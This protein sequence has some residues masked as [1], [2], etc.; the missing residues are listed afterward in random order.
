MK[1]SLSTELSQGA[2]TT[3]V[4]W[5]WCRF[6]PIST[7]RVSLTCSG[8]YINLP[9]GAVT[10]LIITL[11]LKAPAPK[12]SGKT[13]REKINQLDPFG[14]LLFMPGVI[15]LLLALQWGGSTYPWHSA[16]I[17]VL[18]L[19]TGV[20]LFGFIAIQ[21]YTKENATVPPRII[22]QRSIASGFYYAL[23]I[24]STMMI[25]VYFIAI[26]F[27]AIENISAYE[28]GIR[29]L[30]LV[31][32]L[33]VGSALSGALVSAV[34]YYTPFMII[35]TGFMAIGGGLLTTFSV[36]TSRAQ[37]IG[38]QVLFGFGL[39]LALQMPSMAAQTVLKN[40]DV[41]IGASLMFFAQWLGGAIFVSVGQNVLTTKLV[42]GLVSIP[43]FNPKYVTT[44]GATELRKFVPEQFL[45]E[46]L[47]VY[48]GALVKV[49]EIALILSCFS[50]IGALAMEFKSVKERK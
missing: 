27:Q 34:G 18:F 35:G 48:N 50:I 30:P 3:H 29:M 16:R 11:I 15:C 24:G 37:W 22:S 14:T 32:A 6:S 43:G 45:G 23:C 40:A 12:N 8:F 49:F 47:G 41:P 10:M 17:I 1:Q 7:K 19:L 26:W 20:L 42:S 9:I 46:V 5:R 25:L 4:S 21:I 31:L 36:D 13:I 39:G 44:T 28:S 2:F 38:Y 33:V